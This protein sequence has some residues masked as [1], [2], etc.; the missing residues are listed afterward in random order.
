MFLYSPSTLLLYKLKFEFIF[1]FLEGLYDKLNS[2]PNLE[3]VA[4]FIGN[5]SII[6][7]SVPPRLTVSP[8]S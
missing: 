4:R 8:V 2:N 1:H 5:L 6:G 7:T 3:F